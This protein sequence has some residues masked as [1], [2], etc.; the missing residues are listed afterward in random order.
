[1]I[2][3]ATDAMKGEYLKGFRPH[4]VSSNRG[5]RVCDGERDVITSLH[6]CTC[7]NLAVSLMRDVCCCRASSLMSCN[8]CWRLQ[9]SLASHIKQLPDLDGTCVMWLTSSWFRAL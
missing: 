8:Q 6:V 3:L 1:M 7:Q 4:R 2:Q 5:Q 9:S